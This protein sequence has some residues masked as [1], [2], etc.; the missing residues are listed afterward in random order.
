MAS[1]V[2]MGRVGYGRIRMWENECGT[3]VVV[4]RRWLW[5]D[6]GCGKMGMW[7]DGNDG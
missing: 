5:D 6:G 3:M 2:V 4:G 7:A 1:W